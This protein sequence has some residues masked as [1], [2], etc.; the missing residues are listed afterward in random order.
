MKRR[1]KTTWCVYGKTPGEPLEELQWCF[2]S[3][4]KA[5]KYAKALKHDG[6]KVRLVRR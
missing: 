4:M 5:V 1:R 6:I 2:K 3:K